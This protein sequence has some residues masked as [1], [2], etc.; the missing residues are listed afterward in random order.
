MLRAPPGI[1]QLCV[2]SE[3]SP[4]STEDLRLPRTHA[5]LGDLKGEVEEACSSGSAS[6]IGRTRR[7]KEKQLPRG[8][9]EEKAQKEE[10]KVEKKRRKKGEKMHGPEL[11]VRAPPDRALRREVLRW[12]QGLDL[13]HSVKNVRR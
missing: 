3:F 9:C 5:R 4:F 2:E 11:I 1:I 7:G 6:F 12:I 10:G 13:S 8:S